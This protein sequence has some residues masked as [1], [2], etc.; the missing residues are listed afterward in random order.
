MSVL[1]ACAMTS[2]T[3]YYCSS[4][5]VF[6]ALAAAMFFEQRGTQARFHPHEVYR[7]TDLQGIQPQAGDRAHPFNASLAIMMVLGSWSSIMQ[8]QVA[9]ADTKL[10]LAH[11]PEL[12][13]CE[14]PVQMSN[15]CNDQCLM[16]SQLELQAISGIGAQRLLENSRRLQRPLVFA[17]G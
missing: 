6:A 16:V 3:H 9:K 10:V 17:A 4:A 12:R 7:E 5:G 15:L 11:R 14:L 8:L 2:L 13:V 1:R